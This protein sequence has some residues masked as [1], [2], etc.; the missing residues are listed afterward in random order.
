MRIH[1]LEIMM[2]ELAVQTPARQVKIPSEGEI[3]GMGPQSTR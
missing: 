2:E 3:V 1:E